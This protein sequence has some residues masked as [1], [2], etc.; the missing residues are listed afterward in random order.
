VG[1]RNCGGHDRLD[2][3]CE[4][5]WGGMVVD[6]EKVEGPFTSVV[7]RG[8]WSKLSSFGTSNSPGE[9]DK[10]TGRRGESEKLAEIKAVASLNS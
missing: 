1:G 10:I 4:P 5:A 2:V 6:V 3:S 9:G 7:E 8:A